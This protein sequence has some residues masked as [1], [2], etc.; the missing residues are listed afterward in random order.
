M[1]GGAPTRE[2]VAQNVS[3]AGRKE[4]V[5]MA[6]RPEWTEAE[7]VR[8]LELIAEKWSA[9]KIGEKMGKSRNAIIGRCYRTGLKLISMAARTSGP[10]KPRTTRPRLRVIS[11]SLSPVQALFQT[12]ATN[13][14][15]DFSEDMV[16]FEDVKEGQ[17]RWP[18]GDPT[19][20]AFRF[21]GSES[22]AHQSYCPRH[23]RLAYR[24]FTARRASPNWTR[25][26]SAWELRA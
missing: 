11:N 5:V 8:L 19:S 1:V 9:T 2:G 23:C 20:A 3:G 26:L 4:V 17:C 10:Y 15:P 21:C 22:M 12:E 6:D 18:I 25:K 7:Q 16:S 13:L 24:K 14:P